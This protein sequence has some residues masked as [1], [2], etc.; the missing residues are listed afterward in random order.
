MTLCVC[1]Y[2][3]DNVLAASGLWAVCV[4]IALLV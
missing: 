4:I 2:V 3:Y 1:M